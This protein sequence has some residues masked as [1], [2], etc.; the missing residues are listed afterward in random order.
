MD[1]LIR[2]MREKE[3]ITIEKVPSVM[4]LANVLYPSLEFVDFERN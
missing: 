1:N 4:L 2:E 3:L